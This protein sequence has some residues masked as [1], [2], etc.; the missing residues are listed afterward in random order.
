MAV[1]LLLCVLTASFV[2]VRLG[3]AAFELTGL[4]WDEAKFQAL[5]AFTNTGFTTRE[6]EHITNH[7]IRRKIAGY[8]IVSGNAGLVTTIGTFAGS[9][10]SERVVGSLT[11]LAVIVVGI[12]VLLLIFRHP[13]ISLRIREY[14]LRWL[15]QRFQFSPPPNPSELLRLDQG[16]TLERFCLPER[17]SAVGASLKELHLKD[18]TLQILAIERGPR[19]MP[20][21][22]GDDRLVAGDNIIVYGDREALTR[23][24]QPVQ[25]ERLSFVTTTTGEIQAPGPEPGPEPEPEPGPE[26]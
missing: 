26:S 8:L 12:I 21:P 4:P 2:V 23:T 11:N 25:T 18:H 10:V 16:F 3:A 13:A 17:S 19:F 24:F 1:V 5:S 9:L 22:A 14:A 20:I 6:A 7:P 15:G